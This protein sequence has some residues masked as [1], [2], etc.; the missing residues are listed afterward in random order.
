MK[1]LIVV[2]SLVLLGCGIITVFWQQELVYTLPTPVPRGYHPV[3]IGQKPNLVSYLVKQDKPVFMHFFNPECPC[4]RFNIKHFKSLIHEYGSQVEFR[5]II[6]SFDSTF[7]ADA[8]R[9]KYDLD[10][11]CVIDGDESIADSCG[12]YSTPQALILD[13]EGK[14]YYRGNYNR[15]RYCTDPKSDFAKMALDSLLKHSN[16]PAFGLL[17]S[18]PYG[19]SLPSCQNNTNN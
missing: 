16:S 14:L 4:S 11:P 6:Q 12:V 18:R 7:T 8:A 2:V 5:M 3:K 9:E 19:C 17:A 15:A 1:K 10:I 13:R